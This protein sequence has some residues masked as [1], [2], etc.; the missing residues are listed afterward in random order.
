MQPQ[1]T[2]PA[3][4]QTVPTVVYLVLRI[5]AVLWLIAC[6]LVAYQEILDPTR[7]MIGFLCF[8]WGAITILNIPLAFVGWL[9]NIVALTAMVF[10]PFKKYNAAI[11]ISALAVA[12]SFAALFVNEI[13]KDGTG[14]KVQVSVGLAV[15]IWMTSI[16]MVLVASITGKILSKNSAQ[17]N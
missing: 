10:I 4:K 5:S 17:S 16:A 13:Y 11:I 12:C 1:Q 7:A 9:S 15:Y 8:F 14:D 2:T 3:K 6:P